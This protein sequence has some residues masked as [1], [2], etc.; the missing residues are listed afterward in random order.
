M[1]ES[2]KNCATS[3]C[4]DHDDVTAVTA[5]YGVPL[6]ARRKDVAIA[7]PAVIDAA[8]SHCKQMNA[9]VIASFADPALEATRELLDVP[10]TGLCEASVLTAAQLGSRIGI[11]LSAPKLVP[12]VWEK[13]RAY[14]IAERVCAIRTPD[15][16]PRPVSADKEELAEYLQLAENL[17][18]AHQAEVIILGGGPIIGHARMFESRVEIPVID[19]VEAAILQA[20]CLARLSPQPARRGSY[21]KAMVRH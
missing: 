19:C 9:V 17:V 1:T 16:D 10:V 21:S 11:I 18:S 20:L 2:L 5:T 13:L 3:I 4:G 15:V 14:G 6:I 7:A 8:L 12:A